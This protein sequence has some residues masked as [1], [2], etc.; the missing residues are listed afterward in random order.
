MKSF[1]QL[2][3]SQETLDV[4]KKKGFEKPTPIQEKTIPALLSGEKD[5]IGQAQTGTGRPATGE[6]AW[7]KTVEGKMRSYIA[8]NTAQCREFP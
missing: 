3:L 2:G 7:A 6:Y 4:L 5:V 1:E 8:Q